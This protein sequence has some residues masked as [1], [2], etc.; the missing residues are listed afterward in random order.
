MLC[1]FSNIT[2]DKACVTGGFL[3]NKDKT[4]LL[5]GYKA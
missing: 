5:I 3:I 4:Q 2:F 1:N